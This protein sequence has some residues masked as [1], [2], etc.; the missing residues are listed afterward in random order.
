MEHMQR[1]RNK[2][3]CGTVHVLHIHPLTDDE[4][5]TGVTPQ[6]VT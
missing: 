6:V 3:G 1:H 4:I 2:C 5:S